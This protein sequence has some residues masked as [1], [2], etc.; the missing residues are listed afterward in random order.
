MA[1]AAPTWVGDG[2]QHRLAQGVDQPQLPPPR[3][4][5]CQLSRRSGAGAGQCC[6]TT[7]AASLETA[8]GRGAR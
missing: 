8:G 4:Q 1:A 5:Q 3:S 2:Q 6:L 7:A